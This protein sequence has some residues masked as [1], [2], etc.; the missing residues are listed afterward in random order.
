MLNVV[1]RFR[2]DHT[3]ITRPI[4]KA[5]QS[6][7]SLPLS[8]SHS[9]RFC[10]FQPPWMIADI[11]NTLH[12]LHPQTKPFQSPLGLHFRFRVEGFAE[13]IQFGGMAY[14]R[15]YDSSGT[16]DDH[17]LPIS[18]RNR[19]PRSGHMVAS[20]RPGLVG[21]LPW[22]VQTGEHDIEAQIH[23]L[24]REAYSS[25]LK[26]LKV[27][28]DTI[29]W[30]KEHLMTELRKEL[31][32][33]DEEHRELLQKVN[34]DQDIQKMREW[35]KAFQQQPP[36]LMHQTSQPSLSTPTVPTP[37]RKPQVNQ[38]AHS[39]S[40]PVPPMPFHPHVAAPSSHPTLAAFQQEFVMASKNENY[41]TE[42]GVSGTPMVKSVQ[43]PMPCYSGRDQTPTQI[44]P[45]AIKVA[46]KVACNPLIGR[47]VRTRWPEDDN[48]YEAFIA[49]YNPNDGCH[50]LIYDF[51][52]GDETWEWVN[53]SEISPEDIQWV[54]E[55]SGIPCQGQGRGRGAYDVPGN[56]LKKAIQPENIS[57][58]TSG[59]RGRGSYDSP[60]NDLKKSVRPESIPVGTSGGRGRGAVHARKDFPPCHGRTRKK[61][62]E[63]I[64]L[65]H[66]ASLVK[67]AS[68]EIL[69]ISNALI[70][71]LLLLSASLTFFLHL[72]QV[73]KMFSSGDPGSVDVGRVKKALR[74]HEK[75]LV[76]AIARITEVCDGEGGGVSVTPSVM[77][78]NRKSCFRSC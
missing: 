44:D 31:R 50:A 29:T 7:A 49:N 69:T 45:Q 70:D 18:N 63:D 14:E 15:V 47:K 24:E 3:L 17:E 32:L 72:L 68:K 39:H 36:M 30:E 76:D 16:D 64:K 66:T 20:G 78:G 60:G 13:L 8:E 59:G 43:Y 75:A 12:S 56:D 41:R 5:Q 11:T 52:S 74:D 58:V 6:L 71:L 55:D 26:A 23:E 67:E 48:F 54:G 37:Y 2:I 33:S 4:P 57:G 46:D 42:K 21:S 77:V 51:G 19:V 1:L 9:P 25:V 38:L 61:A 34:A 27:Q 65:L 10:R 22:Y 35:R 62:L 28:S 53:L 73:E 40:F